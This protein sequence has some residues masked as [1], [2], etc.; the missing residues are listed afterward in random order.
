MPLMCLCWLSEQV[1][2]STAPEGRVQVSRAQ[3]SVRGSRGRRS[4]AS[5]MLE[6]VGSK[7]IDGKYYGEMREAFLLANQ[8]LFLNFCGFFFD[9]SRG[10]PARTL[11]T[12]R[13][14]WKECLKVWP[15]SR[16]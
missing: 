11:W 15:C 2:E 10:R 4:F 3:S 8:Y 6:D 13:C 9:R 12:S 5:E 1:L 14:G 7:E 16:R